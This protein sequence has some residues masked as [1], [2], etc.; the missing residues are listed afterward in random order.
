[1]THVTHV[2]RPTFPQ[3]APDTHEVLRLTNSHTAASLL[4]GPFLIWGLWGPL[5]SVRT[6]SCSYYCYHDYYRYYLSSSFGCFF[7]PSF[8]FHF[9][10]LCSPHLDTTTKRGAEP[11]LPLVD[12]TRIQQVLHQPVY[13]LL[14]LSYSWTMRSF[15]LCCIFARSIWKR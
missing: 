12:G 9:P 1:M 7:N 4:S 14:C 8:T 6:S 13:M 10:W 15:H 5:R 11:K 3:E 2:A